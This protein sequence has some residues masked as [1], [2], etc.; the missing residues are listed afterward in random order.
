MTDGDRLSEEVLVALRRI[1]RAIDM[2]SKKLAQH[3]G[4][5][6][7]QILI[8][9]R[10]SE[11]PELAVGE[12]A[13]RVSLS[14]ATVTDILDRL[15]R[16]GLVM[17][18]RSTS[19]KRRVLVRATPEGER[20]LENSPPLLQESFVERLRELPDWEQTLILSCLQRVSTMLEVDRLDAAPILS[21]G[22]LVEPPETVVPPA[23][24]RLA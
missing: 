1:V 14:Q 16:R 8:L 19:D 24:A 4:V 20:L 2:H 9:K 17:R 13:K 11:A 23:S 15:E 18:V 21:S 5:T 3:H 7:P 6:G 10:L 22:S 12:L